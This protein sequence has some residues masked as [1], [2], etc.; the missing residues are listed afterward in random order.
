MKNFR[1]RIDLKLF[2]H[3]VEN[4]NKKLFLS[5]NN[6]EDCQNVSRIAR[7][8]E[9]IWL[10]RDSGLPLWGQSLDKLEKG[11]EEVW[12]SNK[13]KQ[14][15]AEENKLNRSGNVGSDNTWQQINETLMKK[16][17]P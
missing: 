16:P 6:W 4:K 3:V 14:T 15:R 13:I 10:T 11:V 8:I 5:K 7:L 2:C 12:P 17:L 1:I 9:L